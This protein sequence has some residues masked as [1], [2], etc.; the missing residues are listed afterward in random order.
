MA[1]INLTDRD[2]ER[3]R[4]YLRVV[5]ELEKTDPEPPMFADEEHDTEPT[6]EWEAWN[7]RG[8]ELTKEYSDVIRLAF[9]QYMAASLEDDGLVPDE[10]QTVIDVIRQ[11]VGNNY[12]RKSPYKRRR[13]DNF[14]L[15]ELKVAIDP[16]TRALFQRNRGHVTAADYWSDKP[17]VIPTGDKGRSV[18]LTLKSTIDGGITADE[19]EYV[20]GDRTSYWLDAVVS[21]AKAGNDV[22]LGS[23][24]LKQNGY[25]NPYSPKRASTMDEAF[26]AVVMAKTTLIA[27]D[28]TGETGR[29]KK[30]KRPTRSME[31]QPIL[32]AEV[33]IDEYEVEEELEDG[34]GKATTIKTRHVKDFRIVLPSG[35]GTLD[36]LP[37]AKQADDRDELLTIDPSEEQFTTVK[38][39]TREERRMWRYVLKTIKSKSAKPT[40]IFDTMFRNLELDPPEVAKTQRKQVRDPKTGKLVTVKDEDGKPVQVPRTEKQIE[41]ATKKAVAAQRRRMIARLEKMMDEKAHPKLVPIMGKD[42]KPR[43]NRQGQVM[44]RPEHDAIVAAYKITADKMTFT[45]GKRSQKKN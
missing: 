35:S 3:M 44:M 32:N 40:I 34:D 36:G 37:L 4:E 9:T 43:T 26:T 21:L 31:L 33:F 13:D 20:L 8:V 12:A 10:A 19:S 14:S 22:I 1:Q 18:S 27:I 5:G 2:R 23:D 7:K 11:I 28:A 41:A 30:G 25:E 39:L 15:V 17:R 42:G 29:L 24:M 16:I 38:R 45:R 6:E